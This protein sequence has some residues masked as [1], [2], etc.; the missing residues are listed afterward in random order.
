MSN[1][2]LGD[3]S[4]YYKYG[5]VVYL[6]GVLVNLILLLGIM[7]FLSLGARNSEEVDIKIPE[8]SILTSV[9]FSSWVYWFMKI[10]GL[11]IYSNE[12]MVIERKGGD[13]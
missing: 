10:T 6:S 11:D 3:S 13:S 12:E 9:I 4:N 2:R 8:I 1:D 5:R 7:V